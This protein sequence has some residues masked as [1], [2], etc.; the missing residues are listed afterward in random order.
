MITMSLEPQLFSISLGLY[1]IAYVH[2]DYT[3]V[4]TI[5]RN[6]FRKTLQVVDRRLR[7]VSDFLDPSN[8]LEQLPIHGAYR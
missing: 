7:T 3:F 1:H 8:W 6:L 2:K 5:T 4:R